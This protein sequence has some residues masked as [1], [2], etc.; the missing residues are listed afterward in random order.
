MPARVPCPPLNDI[1]SSAPA[2]RLIPNKGSSRSHT[3]IPPTAN[4]PID[5]T[6]IMMTCEPEILQ[7]FLRGGRCSPNSSEADINVTS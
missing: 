1:S 4:W 6:L 2:L 3:R 5:I 7:I